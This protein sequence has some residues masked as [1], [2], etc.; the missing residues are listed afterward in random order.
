MALG[1]D[2]SPF[3]KN[4]NACSSLVSFLNV[5]KQVASSSDNFLVFGAN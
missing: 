1:G 4:T 3:G 2:G 5:G